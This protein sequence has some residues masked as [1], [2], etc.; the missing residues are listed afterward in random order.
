MKELQK[1][2]EGLD[3][4]LVLKNFSKA[5]R[6]A[7]G[8]ALKQF[9]V[10]RRDQNYEGRIS[11]DQARSYLLHR[12]KQGLKW[13]TINGD[14]SALFKFF[15]YVLKVSWDVEHIPRPRKERSLP[16]ILSQ[17]QIQQII[18][19]GATFKHQVFMST[20]YATG[21]RL[22]E[23]LGLQ[24]TDINGE[25]LQLR[26]QK[27]KGAK[28]RYVEIPDCLLTLLRH[29]YREYRPKDY[30]FNG[31][32]KGQVWAPRSAQWSIYNAVD[33]TGIKA[34]VSP[35]TFRHCYATHHLEKGTSLVYLKKQLGHKHLKT[36][37]KYIHLCQRYQLQV[38]HP[39]AGMQIHYT[40]NNT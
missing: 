3:A 18:E 16:K 7:Y 6:S 33:R 19:K 28:D 22:G 36:T 25:R 2:L 5:T 32:I 29:Y 4:Y 23:A 17:Q 1:Q 20:L 26:V 24:L 8:C 40:P 34:R 11:Q 12:H 30:L 13:Q 35:H 21:L 15:R 27:G 38:N 14:Y 9:L 10:W 31:K 39:I 37:A